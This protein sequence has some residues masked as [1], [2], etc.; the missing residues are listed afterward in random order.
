MKEGLLGGAQIIINAI[1]TET[2][3]VYGLFVDYLCVV[4][5]TQYP[6]EPYKSLEEKTLD[7]KYN[8]LT[9]SNCFCE[10]I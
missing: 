3:T 1:K 8:N 6:R 2:K 5:N 10:N 4:R 7:G 9:T